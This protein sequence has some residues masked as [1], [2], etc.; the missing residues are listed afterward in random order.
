MQGFFMPGGQLAADFVPALAG[1]PSLTGRPW[2]FVLLRE[3]RP[4][5]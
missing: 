2:L 5:F 1:P 4:T 3:L